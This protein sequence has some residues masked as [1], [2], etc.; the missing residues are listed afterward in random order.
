MT[1]DFYAANLYRKYGEDYL[2]QAADSGHKRLASW[3][4]NTYANWSS[5]Y[6]QLRTPF[7][8]PVYFRGP[9]LAPKLPDVW[10][11]EFTTKLGKVLSDLKD[12]EVH[13]SPWNLGFFVF[14]EI[15][16]KKPPDLA[17]VILG[18]PADQPA[19]VVWV[20]RLAA[21]YDKIEAL[22]QVW[23]THYRSW[24]NLLTSTKQVTYA[25]MA[26]DANQ[27]F[28]DYCDHFFRLSRDTCKEFFPNHLYLG[29]RLHGQEH[30]LVMKAADAY[31]D[32]ISYNLYRKTLAGWNGPTKAFT[33]PVM[34]TEFHF[35]ALDRGMFHTGLQAASNQEDRAEH[36]YEYVRSALQNPLFVGTHWFQYAPQGFTGREDGEN[37]QIGLLDMADTPY[38]ELIRAVRRI[39]AEMYQLRY[40]DNAHAKR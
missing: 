33:K 20:K 17:S 10:H 40:R 28:A 11:P 22:N 32:V 1:Y 4:M 19:K 13:S 2:K 30:P 9:D 7:T 38:P 16:F 26:A 3:G 25:N 39:G 36:Y 18:A 23:Q 5:G 37:Y 8:V 24:E 14:N 34:A 6:E 27:C 29:S 21:K 15:R 12:N 35:G 31:C